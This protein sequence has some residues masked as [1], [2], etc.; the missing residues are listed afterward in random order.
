MIATTVAALGA[1]AITILAPHLDAATIVPLYLSCAALPLFAVGQVQSGI[2]RSYNW[3]NLGLTPV[4]VLRQIV[5][6]ALMGLAYALGLPTDATTATFVGVLALWSV[7]IGQLF[8]LNRRL[9]TK[10]EGGPKAK[11]RFTMQIV[12]AVIA[13]YANITDGEM[14]DLTTMLRRF[15]ADQARE[16]ARDSARAAVA[17]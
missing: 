13:R 17:A 7:T 5:L 12:D 4:F 9:S 10:V 8:V 1:I 14:N 11:Y 16:A 2:A 6:L 15:A 3:V